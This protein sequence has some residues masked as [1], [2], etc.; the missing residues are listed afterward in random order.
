M[1]GL[2]QPGGKNSCLALTEARNPRPENPKEIRK[3]EARRNAPPSDGHGHSIVC[4]VFS[5]LGFLS[6]F[7]LRAFGFSEPQSGSHELDCTRDRMPASRKFCLVG[8]V[9]GT[10][11]LRG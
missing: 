10:S 11:S 9:I 4:L 2:H 3:P 1:P 5:G 7:D 6:D 8:F